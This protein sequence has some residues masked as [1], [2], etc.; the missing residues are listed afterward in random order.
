MKIAFLRLRLVGTQVVINALLG[1][2][3]AIL[4][5]LAMRVNSKIQIKASS[6]MECAAEHTT[7]SVLK[8]MDS[9]E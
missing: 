6:G 1:A 3:C 8:L 5:K 2:K 7:K 9:K 4:T